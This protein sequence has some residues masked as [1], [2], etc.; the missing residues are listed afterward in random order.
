MIDLFLQQLY[1]GRQNHGTSRSIISA[2]CS[3]LRLRLNPVTFANRHAVDRQRHGVH[4]C[5]Q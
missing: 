3:V 4:V 1:D 2:Q 5:H